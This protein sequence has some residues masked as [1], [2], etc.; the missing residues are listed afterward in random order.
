MNMNNINDALESI[1][2]FFNR[3]GIVTACGQI[4][5]NCNC[6]TD[7]YQCDS[8]YRWQNGI[9][10]E[11]IANLYPILKD[12]YISNNSSLFP[13]K[14]NNTN[15]KKDIKFSEFWNNYIYQVIDQ[16]PYNPCFNRDPK[17]IND[18]KYKN[19]CNPETA[20]FHFGK[21]NKGSWGHTDDNLWY[22]LGFLKYAEETKDYK[23]FKQALIILLNVYEFA[24]MN[25]IFGD[26]YTG[27]FW[28]NPT[29]ASGKKKENLKPD[30]TYNGG[31][32]SFNSVTNLQYIICLIKIKNNID[33]YKQLELFIYGNWT[34]DYIKSILNT[35]IENMNIILNKLTLGCLSY[36]KDN[37]LCY[38]NT[39]QLIGDTFNNPQCFKLDSTN[40]YC[41]IF[42]DTKSLNK[43]VYPY[44][45]GLYLYYASIIDNNK[46]IITLANRLIKNSKDYNWSGYIKDGEGLLIS[47]N[48][49]SVPYGC[50]DS[51][52]QNY[53]CGGWSTTCSNGANGGDANVFGGIFL[54]YLS[55]YQLKYNND[56][57]KNLII[58]NSKLMK[59]YLHK[60]N[61]ICDP[62][63]NNSFDPSIC[64]NDKQKGLKQN[65]IKFYFYN[66]KQGPCSKICMTSF[67]SINA[68][69]FYI[70]NELINLSPSP[71]P[72]PSPK[73]I[74]ISII[75]T[76][77]SVLIIIYVIYLFLI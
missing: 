21:T 61:N 46:N 4:G 30:G 41:I 9:L 20:G 71:S 65:Q 60:T 69:L 74:I 43:G 66:F 29:D 55:Y 18:N 63:C 68:L 1:Y 76:I 53:C 11:S 39:I 17:T 51:N 25:Y 24:S 15:L 54:L 22:C 72:S 57:A 33:K 12:K 36:N 58:K 64:G 34:I 40:E 56:I 42:P 8:C 6:N 47:T 19:K 45:T 44:T 7:K 77:L 67:D 2:Y 10:I 75:S 26:E 23:I 13:I 50:Q 70:S 35:E 48:Q 27:V 3:N 49:D 52:S 28:D 59:P 73:N 37:T 38:S 32:L 5:Y 31:K 62:F 16:A 14:I